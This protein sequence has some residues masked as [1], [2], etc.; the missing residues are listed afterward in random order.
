MSPETLLLWTVFTA[1]ISV[2]VGFDLFVL[3]RHAHVVSVR[4]AL[5][6][7]GFW[8]GVSLAFGAGVFVFMGSD[9]GVEYLTA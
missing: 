1:V 5:L 4:E 3:N 2:M 7:T 8:I 6:W 9:S